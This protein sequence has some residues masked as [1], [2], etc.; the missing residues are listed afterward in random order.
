M[1]HS[2]WLW[3]APRPVGSGVAMVFIATLSIELSR[4]TTRT[5]TMRTTRIAHR[6]RWIA[7]AEGAAAMRPRLKPF[8]YGP[9]SYGKD[10][11]SLCPSNVRPRP[12]SPL[13]ERREPCQ[14]GGWS[15]DAVRAPRDDEQEPS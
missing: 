13:S 4:T 6:L 1:A 14:H 9:V 5:L 3:V 7:S 15:G 2:S 12:M 11:A 10:F 8:R